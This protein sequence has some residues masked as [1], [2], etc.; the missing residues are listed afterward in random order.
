M[1]AS[2]SGTVEA[3]VKK[4]NATLQHGITEGI[5]VLFTASVIAT[6]VRAMIKFARLNMIHK[7]AKC[8]GGANNGK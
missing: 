5:T 4:K 1:E 6:K 3:G 8:Q 2:R 7:I